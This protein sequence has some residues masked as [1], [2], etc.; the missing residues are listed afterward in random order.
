[1]SAANSYAAVSEHGSSKEDAGKATSDDA[2]VHRSDAGGQKDGS[3]DKVDGE[4]KPK[5]V[6]QQIKEGAERAERDQREKMK[7][8]AR[9]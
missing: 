2:T 7:Q 3:P 8:A 5:S 6:A 4:E 1:V 9:L